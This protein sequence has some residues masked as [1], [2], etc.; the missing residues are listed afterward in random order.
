MASNMKKSFFWLVDVVIIH[1]LL[2]TFFPSNG[3]YI[4]VKS[5]LDLWFEILHGAVEIS[6]ELRARVSW[7]LI[8]INFLPNYVPGRRVPLLSDSHFYY[9]QSVLTHSPKSY[10]TD[11]EKKIVGSLLSSVPK[12]VEFN[13]YELKVIPLAVRRIPSASEVSE[14]KAVD[15]S[16]DKTIA[17]VAQKNGIILV[18]STENLIELW[19]YSTE[20]ESISCCTFAPDDSGNVKISYHSQ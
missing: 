14:I 17:A 3:D 18:I 11:N 12:F 16:H 13:F 5:I 2:T 7:N 1:V 8:E 20:Y 4:I 6:D 19:Q 10:L 15:V 9:L